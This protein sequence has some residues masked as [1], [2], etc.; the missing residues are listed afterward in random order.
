MIFLIA[1]IFIIISAIFAVLQVR[2]SKGSENEIS[3]LDIK[4]IE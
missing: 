4:I 1:L 2:N 3:G